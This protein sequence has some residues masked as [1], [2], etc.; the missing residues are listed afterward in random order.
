MAKV[1]EITINE[2]EL[3]KGT[4][5]ADLQDAIGECTEKLDEI[6]SLR[7]QLVRAV[8][9]DYD[10]MMHVITYQWECEKSPMGWCAYNYPKDP[11]HDDCIF[12]HWPNERK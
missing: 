8:W 2:K 1:V 10:W 4:L 6:T 12:C 3:F 7:A 5:A 9:S 11:A